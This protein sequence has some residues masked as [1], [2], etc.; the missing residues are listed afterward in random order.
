ML[1]HGVRRLRRCIRRGRV[2]LRLLR[3][4]LGRAG[5]SAVLQRALL[6]RLLLLGLLLIRP[7]EGA[8]RWRVHE[9]L[10][11]LLQRLLLQ[12]RRHAWSAA[13]SHGGRERGSRGRREGPTSE[14]SDAKAGATRAGGA[15]GS[16]C[17]TPHRVSLERKSACCGAIR[18]AARQR[19]LGRGR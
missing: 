11:L 14:S 4:K 7:C 18:K 5:A 9:T 6:L 12:L 10:T 15:H 3:L 17:S 19:A 2:E 1:L 13:I 16:A 8:T